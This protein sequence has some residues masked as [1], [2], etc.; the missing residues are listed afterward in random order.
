MSVGTSK[1]ISLRA[2]LQ[3]YP[4]LLCR[5]DLFDE[6]MAEAKR[7][8]SNRSSIQTRQIGVRGTT[9]ALVLDSR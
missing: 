9:I 6:S 7:A 8:V 2:R 3:Q 4:N 5:L 1:R